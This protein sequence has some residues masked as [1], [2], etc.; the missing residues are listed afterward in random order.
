MLHSRVGHSER[1]TASKAMGRARW[2]VR[3][4]DKAMYSTQEHRTRSAPQREEFVVVH[5]VYQPLVTA[6]C[7]HLDISVF[8]RYDNSS[9][10]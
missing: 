9:I 5:A 7:V 1:N 8:I 4:S 2:Q 6:Q 3:G 10:D